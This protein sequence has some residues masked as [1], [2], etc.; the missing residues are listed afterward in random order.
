MKRIVIVF[1][2][3]FLA[4]SGYSQEILD[5]SR[6][7]SI[8][9]F[10]DYNPYYHYTRFTIVGK[11]TTINDTVYKSILYTYREDQS[12]WRRMGFAREYPEGTVYFRNGVNTPEYIVLDFNAHVGDVMEVGSADGNSTVSMKVTDIDYVYIGGEYRRRLKMEILDYKYETEWIEDIGSLNGFPYNIDGLTGTDIKSL[13]CAKKNGELLYQKEGYN[14]CYHIYNGIEENKPERKSFTIT[15]NPV[16]GIAYI[17]VSEFD[18]STAS[19][20]ICNLQ[21]QIIRQKELNSMDDVE[22]NSNDFE[23]GVYLITIKSKT[24]A[25]TRKIV[26]Y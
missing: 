10:Y 7:W 8:L 3:A 4:I 6:V 17:N 25:S 2:A 20:I 22:I 23:P 21:G 13:L 14:T 15:P 19:I 24:F 18:K 9:H 5:T 12:D 1:F 11:D 26:I 16:N